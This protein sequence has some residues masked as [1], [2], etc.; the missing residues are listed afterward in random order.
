MV[1][2]CGLRG[3]GS[4]QHIWK[5]WKNPGPAELRCL[6]ANIKLLVVMPYEM[7]PVPMSIALKFSQSYW[8][9]GIFK[10]YRI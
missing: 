1:G 8:N 2:R 5:S 10:F 9:G 7:F 6:I 4:Q 3:T